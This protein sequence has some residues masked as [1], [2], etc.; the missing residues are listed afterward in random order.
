MNTVRR[1]EV[2]I[3]CRAVEL[4]ISSPVFAYNPNAMANLDEAATERKAREV[5]IQVGTGDLVVMVMM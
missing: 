4:V 1:E 2:L 3:R 5:Y